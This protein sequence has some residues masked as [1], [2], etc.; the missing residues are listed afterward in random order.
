MDSLLS[1]YGLF[2]PEPDEISVRISLDN[3]WLNGVIKA[4]PPML[5]SPYWAYFPI[6]QP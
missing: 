1:C 2:S 4:E 3:Y 6:R 5:A